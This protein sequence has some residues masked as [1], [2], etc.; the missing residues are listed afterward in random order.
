MA[1]RNKA[2][3]VKRKL[4]VLLVEDEPDDAELVRLTL[5]KGGFDV[6]LTVTDSEGGFLGALAELPDIIL[7]D[8]HLPAFSGARALQLAKQH[9]PR[10]PFI[11]LSGSV[12]EE[13]AVELIKQGAND[14]LLKDRLARLPA[15]VE[16]AIE[17]HRLKA[18]KHAAEAALAHSERRFR[19]LIE[20]AVNPVGLLD[21]N[22]VV[23]Y[24]SPAMLRLTGFDAQERVGRNALE[25]VHP[26]HVAAV[27]AA[28]CRAMS[29][30]GASSSVEF[31][32]RT[33]D[34]SWRW[35]H[36]V[37]TNLLDD[38]DVQAVVTNLR[39]VTDRVEREQQLKSSEQRLWGVIEASYDG[40]WEF[41]TR[42]GSVFWS[43][44]SYEMLGLDPRVF[45][46]DRDAFYELVHPDDRQRIRI[47]I[48]TAIARCDTYRAQYRIR[49]ADGDYRTVESRG[50]PL[51]NEQGEVIAMAGVI[52]LV[53]TE[54]T[55]SS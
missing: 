40:Y 29:E 8:Y 52:S 37:Y 35:M 14:Y 9:A 32:L 17:Q 5:T 27:N 11:L 23:T 16:S 36:A 41:D 33:R 34:G 45:R 19:A 15:A 25:L 39:D 21:R 30:A 4:S 1:N 28:L 47:Q 12:G 48:E 44:R 2:E 3:S 22:A 10:L 6:R 42:N 26:D 20:H 49:H 38:P 53:V 55:P 31:R 7:S 24:I 13:V 51:R 50:K 43:Q 46:A 54:T 18:A